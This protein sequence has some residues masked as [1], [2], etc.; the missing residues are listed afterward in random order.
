MSKQERMLVLTGVNFADKE[1]VYGNQT[2]FMQFMEDIAEGKA[3]TGLDINLE[4]AWRKSTSSSKRTEHVQR[5]NSGWVK[6]N[7]IL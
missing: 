2:F 5:C 6:R 3:R 1:H 7:T 4:P